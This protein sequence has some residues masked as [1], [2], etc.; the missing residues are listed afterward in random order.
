[1]TAASVKISYCAQVVPMW[2]SPHIANPWLVDLI[3]MLISFAVALAF[4]KLNDRVARRGWLPEY[5]TRKLVHIGAGPLFLLCWPLYS[6]TWH[7][8]WFAA[9]VPG[10]LT[11]LFA[12]IG[13]GIIKKDDFVAAMSRTGDRRELLRGPLMYGIVFVAVTLFFWTSSPVGVILLMLL[14]GGDGLADVIGRRFGRAKLPGQRD[15]SWAG[16]AGFFLGGLMFSLAFLAYFNTVGFLQLD[17]TAALTPLFITTLAATVVEAYTP[18]D[19]DNLTVP[20]AA[21]AALWIIIPMSNW[22]QVSFVA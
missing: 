10:S 2:L 6:T 13:L 20:A 5:L 14:C 7:A 16:S 12:L 17:L 19:L 9:F 22:W 11:V 21:L 18:A 8:R 15:K 4:L 1:M 3:A